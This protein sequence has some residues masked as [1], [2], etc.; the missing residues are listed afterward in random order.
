MNRCNF[1]GRIATDVDI[2]KTQSDKSVLSFQLAVDSGYG[3]SKTT[4]FFTVILWNEYAETM[5][6]I[7]K[8]GKQIGV[9]GEIH[10][11]DYSDK[12]NYQKRAV[13]ITKAEITLCG[14]KDE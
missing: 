10:I 14:K 8:K 7:L 2:R 5:G 12:N 4:D 13:E 6:K 11:R 9:T 1:I 3:D